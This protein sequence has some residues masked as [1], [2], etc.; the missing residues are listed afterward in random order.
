M[1]HFSNNAIRA[2][3]LCMCIALTLIHPLFAQ[4]KAAQED[5]SWKQTYRAV[6]TKINNLKHTKLVANFNYQE[7]QMNGEVWLKFQPHF[8]PTKTLVLDAKAMDIKEVALMKW[9]C[10]NKTI[11]YL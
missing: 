4:S 3:I 6:A 1:K 7:S 11:L 2:H 10:K 5:S 8:Y 9:C